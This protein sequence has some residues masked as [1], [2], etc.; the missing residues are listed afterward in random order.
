MQIKNLL[1]LR[2]RTPLKSVLPLFE[3][4]RSLDQSLYRVEAGLYL[5]LTSFTETLEKHASAP[6][7]SALI[8]ATDDGAA[9]RAI[10]MLIEEDEEKLGIPPA[11]LLPAGV[12]KAEYGAILEASRRE[13]KVVQETAVYRVATDGRFVH[14]Q[15][16]T[17]KH[18][19]YFRHPRQ[20]LREIPYAI[21]YK[22]E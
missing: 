15:I 13:A 18:I 21:M 9:Q 3:P 20:D 12:S 1:T 19:F 5:L 7:V 8:W 14:R 10:L 17:E 4:E 22:Y 6:F 2:K 11:E 16:E